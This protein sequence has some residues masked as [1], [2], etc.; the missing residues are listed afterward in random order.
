VDD[1]PKLLDKYGRLIVPCSKEL[2]DLYV[3]QH[4]ASQESPNV[5]RL[6]GHIPKD[7]ISTSKCFRCHG[8]K[9]LTKHHV[10]PQLFLKLKEI[11]GSLGKLANI[12]VPLCSGC[13]GLIESHNNLEKYN[14]G[15]RLKIFTVLYEERAAIAKKAAANN[16]SVGQ[17]KALLQANW[18]SEETKVYLAKDLEKL[19]IL[20]VPPHHDTMPTYAQEVLTRVDDLMW[21]IFFWKES[22][23]LHLPP[24]NLP[25]LWALY[26]YADEH[27]KLPDE[28]MKHEPT[29]EID[30]PLS[31]DYWYG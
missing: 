3:D 29:V 11:W 27:N 19:P 9:S 8:K 24:S 28:L 16:K 5:Y 6:N 20:E 17:R 26:E 7:E 31:S 10:V 25:K 22:F 4:W 2:G 14:L 18:I 12:T 1:S 21:L 15:F 13:H 23:T 30:A